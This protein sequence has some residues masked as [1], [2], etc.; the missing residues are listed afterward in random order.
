MPYHLS[1][2]GALLHSRVAPLEW[3][4]GLDGREL[5][6]DVC[7]VLPV[8]PSRAGVVT[9]RQC[10]LQ[11]LVECEIRGRKLLIFSVSLQAWPVKARVTESTFAP[12]TLVELGVVD[13]PPRPSPPIQRHRARGT[14]SRASGQRAQ[15]HAYIAF[16]LTENVSHRLKMSL[17]HP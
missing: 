15:G 6:M 13:H 4:D 5:E 17:L 10:K 16:I 7:K 14:R 2:K 12:V 3:E 1:A 8:L 11:D 9:T